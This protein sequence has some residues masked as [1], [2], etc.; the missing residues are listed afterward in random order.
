MGHEWPRREAAPTEITEIR[1]KDGKVIRR[2]RR[3]IRSGAET[4][5]GIY[6]RVIEYV[7]LRGQRKIIRG[8]GLT[9][10]SKG[11]SKRRHK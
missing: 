1:N 3:I 11:Q 4:F 10:S 9:T 6:R 2:A 7:N 8:E 5:K